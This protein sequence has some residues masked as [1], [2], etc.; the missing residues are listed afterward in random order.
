MPN[1]SWIEETK[2]S[3]VVPTP[4]ALSSG[5]YWPL[6]SKNRS[7]Y[8]TQVRFANTIAVM[9]TYDLCMSILR[10]I[11]YLDDTQICT[12]INTPWSPKCM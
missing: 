12:L 6:S 9:N 2:P 1:K 10:T 5:R 4:I 7:T 8:N 3:V 11:A